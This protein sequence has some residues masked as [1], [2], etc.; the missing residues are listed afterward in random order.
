MMEFVVD[1]KVFSKRFD[2]I[3]NFINLEMKL[4]YNLFSNFKEKYYCVFE[5]DYI[6]FEQFE[7]GFTQFIRLSEIKG[8]SILISDPDPVEVYFKLFNLYPLAI[9]ESDLQVKDF[10]DFF[11]KKFEP[12]S[13]DNNVSISNDICFLPKSKEWAMFCS[14]DFE[15]AIFCATTKEIKNQLITSLGFDI[16]LDFSMAYEVRFIIRTLDLTDDG[17]EMYDLLAKNYKGDDEG[18]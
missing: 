4:P 1:S 12:S 11:I 5:F 8:L 10:N 14:R 7:K 2:E 13:F 18:E 9:F 6:F 17:K 16:T 3:K 15:V